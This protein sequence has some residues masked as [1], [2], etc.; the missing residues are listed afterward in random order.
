M[1]N[2]KSYINLCNDAG[3]AAETRDTEACQSQKSCCNIV[4]KGFLAPFSN[5][6]QPLPPQPPTPLLVA[7]FL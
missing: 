7:L 4:D 2:E 3:V 6:V 5:F 1:F